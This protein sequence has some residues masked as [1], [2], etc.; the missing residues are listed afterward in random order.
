MQGRRPLLRGT[1]VDRLNS[2]TAQPYP[3]LPPSGGTS[4][5]TCLWAH[6]AA[7]ETS[8]KLDGKSKCRL[9][10]ELSAEANDGFWPAAGAFR[11]LAACIDGLIAYFFSF[12]SA[13][14]TIVV[15][16]KPKHVLWS[17][18]SQSTS[19]QT[20]RMPIF[21]VKPLRRRRRALV[22]NRRKQ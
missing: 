10:G 6:V 16:R 4:L 22:W 18:A 5:N 2:G 9:S 21:H 14:N 12:A 7:S 11:L 8:A 19:T 15:S 3:P 1:R 20:E 17:L 13:L